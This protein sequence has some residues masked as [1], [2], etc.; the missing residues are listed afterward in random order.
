MT[1]DARGARSAPGGH[2]HAVVIGSSL[3][4]LTAARALAGFMD[5]V[6]VV[7]RD[8]LP[9][10]PGRRP[11]VPQARH[12]H[13]LVDDAHRGLERLF[14]GIGED[15]ERAG[16]LRLRLP[17]DML[18]LG[19]AGWLPRHDS[20]LL[21]YSAGRDLLDTVIRDRLRGDPRVTFLTRHEAVGLHG[22]PHDSV[23]G[24]WV[25]RRER[26]APDAPG[27]RRLLSAQFVVD[28]SGRASRAPRWLTE[29]GYQT[30]RQSVA[31]TGTRQ[32]STLYAPPLGHV[33]DFTG[34][35]ITP[36]PGDRR[37]A[38]LTPV[39]G[40]R[41]AVT[42]TTGAGQPPPAGHREL[43]AAAA[44]LRDPL[45]HRLIAPAT[46]LG[47][48]YTAHGESRWRHYEQL[49]RWPEGFLVL[50]DA[51]VA[52]D[53]AHG[54]GMTLA[55]HSALVLEHLLHAHGTPTGIGY[56]LRRALAHQLA[57]AWRAHTRPPGRG[58]RAR[59]AQRLAAAARTDRHAAAWLLRRADGLEPPG[60]LGPR[61]LL[62]ALHGAPGAG[63]GAPPSA[64]HGA[65]DARPRPA[66]PARTPAPGPPTPRQAANTRSIRGS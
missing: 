15:L 23:T 24:V 46:P 12:P 52:L 13:R 61:T 11:G 17:R 19:P 8:W 63:P 66:A 43:L 14:P 59:Y 42:L 29:L 10:G 22:G 60:A 5:H 37:S 7:E 55:V 6:T 3:A 39:E 58:P 53:P 26:A 21:A 36:A 35:Q 41:W 57:P 28:A 1:P 30:P 54:H 65:R 33:G 45:L 31:S 27:A 47:P 16:A 32:V 64:T 48:L 18:L 2:G 38:L 51:F 9:R 4:G 62:A 44:A 34:L 25:R 50:G 56:R 49:R 20:G 40:G